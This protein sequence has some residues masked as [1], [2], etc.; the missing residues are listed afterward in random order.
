MAL[1]GMPDDSRSAVAPLDEKARPSWAATGPAR[2]WWILGVVGVAQLMVV[3][4]ATIV[5]IALPSA[6]RDLGFSN[7]DRQWVVTAYSLAFGGLLLLGGRLSD[8]V[9]R[10]RMLIIGLVGFA[11]AS[12]VGGAATSFAVLVIGRGAQG[13]FGAML[14]PAA[15]STLAV[16]FTDPAERGKAFGVYGAIAGAGGAVGLLLGGVLT[17][18]LSWRWCLYVNVILAVVAVAGAV[19]LLAPQARDPA[20]RIDWPGTVLVVAGLV[21]LVYGLS[22]AETSGWGAPT[23]LVLLAVGAV[24]LVAFVLVERRVAHPLLPLRIVLNRFR[25]GAYLAIG[26][27]AIGVFGIFLFLT[28]YLQLTLAYSPVKSGLA[29]LPMIAAIVAA[30]TIS[31]GVLMPRIGPR[32]LIVAGMVI[33]AGGLSL[34][35]AQLGLHSSYL[36]SILPA[37]LLVGAGL[38]LVFGCALNAATYDTGA[39][40]AGVASALVNTNQQVGGSIGTALL[41]T[42]AASAL[43]SYVLAHG[44]GPLVL[45]QAAVHSYVVAFWVSAA[46]LAGSA[47]ICALV[48]PSGILAPAAGRAALPAAQP[49]EEMSARDP[50]AAVAQP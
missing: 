17:E 1:N 45:A 4:D 47:V 27:S 33:A 30:S 3:L 35:A 12:A 6:Q 46:I 25:G 21:S 50:R 29:F 13:A 8:L 23:T 32:P 18:Y 40:D 43:S 15:L 22:K 49:R 9:G 31:S 38:G 28:F 37:L 44:P 5:N 7:A 14:A 34:L 10:R 39:A 36:N 20:V 24:L 11:A 48:L 26:L 19:R 42:I 16:T 2:R 41:N